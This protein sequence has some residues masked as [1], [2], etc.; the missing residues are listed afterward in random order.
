M[1]ESVIMFEL[2]EHQFWK[3]LLLR[4]LTAKLN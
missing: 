3:D 2:I 1:N 4:I